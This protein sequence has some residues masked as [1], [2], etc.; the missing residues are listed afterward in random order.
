[1]AQRFDYLLSL[2][3]RKRWSS[4]SGSPFSGHADR[5]NTL[6]QIKERFYWPDYYKDTMEIL[7]ITRLP[8]AHRPS[9][10]FGSVF[11]GTNRTLACSAR[12]HD[13]IVC[14]Q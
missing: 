13:I 5:D 8:V 3:K 6:T 1:M 7:F 14:V 9:Y 10:K 12:A 4:K 2:R 11:P